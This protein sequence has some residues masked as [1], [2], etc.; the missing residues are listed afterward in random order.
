MTGAAPSMRGEAGPLVSVVTPFY[1]TDRFLEEAIESVLRQSYQNWE[2]VLV[3][4]CSTDESARIAARYAERDAR[5]RLIHNDRL[6]PQ[7]ENY[8]HALRQISARSK[9]C[10]IVQADDWISERCLE[11]MVR[12]AEQA[13][14][15][16]LVSSYSL[17]DP[18]PVLGSRPTV[19]N[20]GLAYT[21]T[22]VPG[23]EMLRRYLL[24][25]LS[26]FGSPTCVM[27]RANDIRAVPNFF[28]LDSPVE[29][30]EAC[31]DVL[32]NGDFAF[33][34]QVLTFNRCEKDSTWWRLAG[35]DANALN[36]VILATK[37]ATGL[38]S[39][40]E[41]VGLERRVSGEHYRC[42]G[43]AVLYRRP[44]EYWEYHKTGL[45]GVGRRIAPHRLAWWV[46]RAI[47]DRIAN[48]KATMGEIVR[49]SRAH[50][51]RNTPA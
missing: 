33:V 4:N 32:Q 6:L 36:K 31:F 47:G 37:Y 49:A 34:H 1:N 38:L 51:G 16:A 14:N 21:T 43:N 23:R 2:Y 46:A 24:E 27:F 42:L 48:P 26:V 17:Y 13:P 19:G 10:K 25:Y 12:A 20:T 22:L 3:N 28:H 8:N 44:A 29:D 40:E 45:A 5:I 15:V 11:D 50:D 35:W 7:V 39:P 18:Q 9:Y 41:C 30:I